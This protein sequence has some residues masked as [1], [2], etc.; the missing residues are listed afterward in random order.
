MALGQRQAEVIFAGGDPP[1]GLAGEDHRA[2][3]H[4]N[5]QHA[6]GRRREHRTFARLLLDHSAVGLGRRDLVNRDVVIHFRLVDIGLADHAASQQLL[7]AVERQ[8]GI[9]ELRI[10]LLDPRVGGVALEGQLL[11][12]HLGDDLA[13]L[14]LLAFLD[15]D[16]ADGAADARARRHDIAALDLAEHRLELGDGDGFRRELPGESRQGEE[17]GEGETG[18]ERRRSDHGSDSAFAE[19]ECG[20]GRGMPCPHGRPRLRKRPCRAGRRAS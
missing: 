5:R 13:L 18:K 7:R 8:L 20:R 10:E 9:V 6:A 17:G 14:H 1:D 16:G 11:V 3:R 12:D 2:E 19:R 4:R 15:R